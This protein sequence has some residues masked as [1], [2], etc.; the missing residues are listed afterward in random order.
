M[1]PSLNMH[2][3]WDFG[4]LYFSF[5]PYLTSL[6]L[7]ETQSSIYPQALYR[8]NHSDSS[9]AFLNFVSFSSCG[10]LTFDLSAA[11]STQES[12]FCSS[13]FIN[14]WFPLEFKT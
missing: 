9:L 1:N 13:F 10:H 5:S 3:I 11:T 14:S 6:P 8:L 7:P 12:P 2:E 4:T